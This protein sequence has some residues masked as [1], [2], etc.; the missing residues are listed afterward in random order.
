MS[1]ILKDP[2]KVFEQE[3]LKIGEENEKVL[4]ISCD[5]ASG[6][7][8]SK[9]IEKFP[10]RYV[11]MGIEEQNAISVCAGLSMQGYIPVIVAITPFIT[12]RSYEQVRDDIGYRI[13]KYECENCWF[14]RWTCLFHF[15]FNT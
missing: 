8:M 7:G 3:F 2:R 5:S 11:E 15:R 10:D 4:A 9:F 12:M 13:C 6:G 1:D 14:W